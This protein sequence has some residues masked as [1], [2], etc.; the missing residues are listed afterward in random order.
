MRDCGDAEIGPRLASRNR[1]EE[2]I[3]I[4]PLLKGSAC[5][6]SDKILPQLNEQRW[7]DTESD[8]PGA[9]LVR[10]SD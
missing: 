7:K 10:D 2:V 5:G 3:R 9:G 1:A 8:T 4:S 6:E